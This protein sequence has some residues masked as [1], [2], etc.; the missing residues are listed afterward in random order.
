M[1]SLAPTPPPAPTKSGRGFSVLGH[2]LNTWAIAL[3]LV[4]AVAFVPWQ[5]RYQTK[6]LEDMGKRAWTMGNLLNITQDKAVARF[7][8][9][10]AKREYSLQRGSFVGPRHGN[11][12]FYLLDAPDYQQQLEVP[13]AIAWTYPQFS[14]V[15]E[16]VWKL[17]DSYLT[18]WFHQPRAE[19]DLSGEGEITLPVFKEGDWVALDNFRVG[20]D[21]AVLQASP[22]PAGR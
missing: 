21:I 9:P 19:I 13:G 20:K 16:M 11:K 1:P 7:G 2:K 22:A 3:A 8:Q 15:R 10:V 5:I 4:A 18:I 6:R 17:P 12:K 14:T